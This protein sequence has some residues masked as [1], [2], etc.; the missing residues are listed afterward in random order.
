MI[1][2]A[3]IQYVSILLVFLW[4][5][6]RIKMFVFQNQVFATTPVSPIL[7]LSPVLSYKQHQSWGNAWKLKKCGLKISTCFFFLCTFSFFFRRSEPCKYILSMF[8]SYYIL[9]MLR[10][11]M[12]GC[13]FL[14][15]KMCVSLYFCRNFGTEVFNFEQLKKNLVFGGFWLFFF[16]FFSNR[17]ALQKNKTTTKTKPQTSIQWAAFE[18]PKFC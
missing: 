17:I 7:P 8:C 14:F 4:V 15:L 12:K 2:F 11:V 13:H 1:K 5:F 6:G 10:L 18:W 16:F 9:W 3:W